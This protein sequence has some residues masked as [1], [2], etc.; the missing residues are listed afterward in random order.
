MSPHRV[1]GAR[2][3]PRSLTRRDQKGAEAMLRKLMWPVL[4]IG[5]VLIVAPFAIQL[6][7]RADGGQKMIDAFGPIMDEQNVQ[8]TADYYYDV[9]VPLGDVV[10][11]MSQEN[12][13]RFNAYVGG[14]DAVGVEAQQLIPAMATAMNM[15]EADV[16]GFMADQFPALFGMLQNIPQ[17]Q[18]DFNGL[19]GLMQQNVAIFE[20]VPAGLA[21]YEPLVTTMQEQQ[22]NYDKVSSLP[23]FR[24]FTWFFIVPGVLLV[25]LAVTGLYL[26]RRER[27]RADVAAE[28]FTTAA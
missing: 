22:Q 7:D 14:F 1:Q 8:T 16:Q 6:P 4:V 18:E 2:W 20:Q 9:F 13:D 28:H 24:L 12:I 5:L 19:L 3:S 21:H 23:D 27:Q 11:A 15:P 25:A 26:D 10:P 17:M